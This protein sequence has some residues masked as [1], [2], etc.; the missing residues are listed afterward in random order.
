[1]NYG[2]ESNLLIKQTVIESR[3]FSF[4]EHVF[5]HKSKESPSSLKQTHEI[6]SEKEDIDDK[7]QENMDELEIK[8]APRR[9]KITRF[10]N[11]IRRLCIV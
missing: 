1:M 11:Q 7:E 9:S 4:S 3:N 10:F 5:P 2:N 8:D 6:N